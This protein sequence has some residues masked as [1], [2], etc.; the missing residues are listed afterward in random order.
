VGEES[1]NLDPMLTKVALVYDRETRDSV[2]R[3]LTLLEPAVIIVMGVM[4]AGIIVSILV[5]ILGANELL[6]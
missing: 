3:M 2:Q 5:A 4:V 6:F 1:G